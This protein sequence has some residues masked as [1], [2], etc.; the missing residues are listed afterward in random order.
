MSSKRVVPIKYI[1]RDYASIREALIEHAKRYYPDTYKDF[2]EPGL[3]SLI[4]DSVSYVGDVL[5]FYLDYQTNESFPDTALEYN[6]ILRHAKS[7]GYR[8]LGN[9]SSYGAVQV[10]VLVPALTNALGPDSRYMPVLKKGSTFNSTA[11]ASFILNEDVDFSSSTDF[12]AAQVN[13]QTGKP[14]S[15]AVRSSGH[16]ISG[17]LG[18]E[19]QQIGAYQKFLKLQL[20]AKNV[21]E[22]ISVI[23]AEG[24]EYFEVTHLSQ[25]TVLRSIINHDE[26]TRN[27][28]N[29]LLR[30][31][32]V[33]RRFVVDR[34]RTYTTL[35]FGSGTDA[36]LSESSVAE[37]S[38]VAL[39]LYG[40]QYVSDTSFDPTKL[41]A[42]DKYGIV[43]ANTALRI[44]YRYNNVDNVN[45]SSGALSVVGKTDFQFRNTVGLDRSQMQAVQSSLEVN[46]DVPIVGDVTLPSV[47][48]VKVRMVDSFAAQSRAVTEQDYKALV[49]AMPQ[50][51]GAIKRVGVAKGKTD[52]STRTLNLYVVSED[53]TGVLTQTNDAI[54]ENLRFWLIKNKMINDVVDI[55]DAKIINLAI[56]FEF[57]AA[58][59]RDK[60]EV[61]KRAVAAL[62][63]FFSNTSNVGEDFYI[64]DVYS[65]LRQVDDVL[66]VTKVKVT[67]KTGANYSS[68]QFDVDSNTSAD[69]RSIRCPANCIFEV[70]YV[71]DD[72]KG[73]VI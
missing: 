21:S 17:A 69:G 60:Y 1:N 4:I 30:P 14:T 63:D 12:V 52:S 58:S 59:D 56:E 65:V 53:A 40:K 29:N 39:N 67:Q 20:T 13:A 71:W 37:P 24:H 55:H 7:Y 35:M 5:S 15:Y 57:M 25:N 9:P 72:V 50:S 38:K 34:D 11:G 46:N 62:K 61:Y 43:P 27:Y 73:N 41:L 51:F 42:T 32:I 36:T 47:E 64:T 22:I 6:N 66:D 23:D 16:V 54:K 8:F 2:S 33:P 3:G 70:K 48:E 45:V 18:V 28:A 19:Y 44:V 26:N 49:Y 68:V 31:Y 10:F